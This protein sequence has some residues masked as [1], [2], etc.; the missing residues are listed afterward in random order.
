MTVRTQQRGAKHQRSTKRA[1]AALEYIITYGWGFIVILIVLGGLAYMGYLNPSRYVPAR[2]GFGVQ[3]ECT[4]YRIEA[5]ILNNNGDLV[6]NGNI[7]IVL[8]NNLGA[9]IN[10]TQITT[11]SGINIKKYQTVATSIIP[12]GKSNNFTITLIQTADSIALIEGERASVPLIVTF[13]RS[14]IS[15]APEHNITGEIFA[16][17]QKRG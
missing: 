13:K 10:I 7:T 8:R 2:C 15:D 16:T 14:N 12:K 11:A 9:D 1:Q 3:L 4:D 17:V 5:G 6:D